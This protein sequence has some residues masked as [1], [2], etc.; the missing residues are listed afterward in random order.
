MHLG[1]PFVVRFSPG[2]QQHGSYLAPLGRAASRAFHMA[3]LTSIPSSPKWLRSAL[4]V[5]GRFPFRFFFCIR[6]VIDG[7]CPRPDLKRE[8]VYLLLFPPRFVLFLD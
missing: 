7:A 1:G 4:P 6:H 2:V 5:P 3:A 8:H